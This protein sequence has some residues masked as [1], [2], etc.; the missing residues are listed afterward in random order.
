MIQMEMQTSDQITKVK[1]FKK[2]LEMSDL[3]TLVLLHQC[4]KLSKT[5]VR[6]VESISQK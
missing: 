1:T 3:S 6:F 5:K 2:R 4:S